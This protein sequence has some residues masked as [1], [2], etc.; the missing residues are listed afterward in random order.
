[1]PIPEKVKEKLH[2]IAEIDEERLR[3]LIRRRQI[4]REIEHL[5][6]AQAEVSRG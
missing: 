6:R 1:M 5:E 3:L 2:Q 4:Q